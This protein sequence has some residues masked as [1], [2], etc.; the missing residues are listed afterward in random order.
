MNTTI[1]M[2][3]I[4]TGE[5]FLKK[6]ERSRADTLKVT[7]KNKITFKLSVH[8][9]FKFLIKIQKYLKFYD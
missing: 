1:F 2:G 8:W 7:N 5:M 4:S 9:F 6:P 3:K